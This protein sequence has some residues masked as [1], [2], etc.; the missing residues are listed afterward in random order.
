MSDPLSNSLWSGRYRLIEQVGAGGMGV[1]YRAEDERLRRTV[2]IKVMARDRAEDAE[3]LARFRRE[4]L[5]VAELRHSNV[6]VV[7][8]ADQHDG[9]PS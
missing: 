2:A 5:A 9:I 7:H 1:V 4:I 8:D 6:I 3:A